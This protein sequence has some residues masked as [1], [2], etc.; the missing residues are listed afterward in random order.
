MG[1]SLGQKRDQVID[2]SEKDQ[3]K[4]DLLHTKLVYSSNQNKLKFVGR[5]TRLPSTLPFS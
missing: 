2:Y 5:N 3:F 4:S 1:S